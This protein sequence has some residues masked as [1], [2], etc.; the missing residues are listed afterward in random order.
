MKCSDCGGKV[1]TLKK[2]MKH[3][4]H[5]RIYNLKGVE[6]EK[7]LKCGE[8][9]VTAQVI[10]DITRTLDEQFAKENAPPRRGA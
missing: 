9:T 8:E 10:E 1:V 4:R 3:Y 6:V 2:P 7:C 5:G